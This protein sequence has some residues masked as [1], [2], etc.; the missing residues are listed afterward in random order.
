MRQ[1]VEIG[2]KEKTPNNDLLFGGDTVLDN[3]TTVEQWSLAYQMQRPDNRVQTDLNVSIF[4][5][6]LAKTRM[7]PIMRNARAPTLAI[8]MPECS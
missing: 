2:Y 6:L 3:D 4:K 5:A 8:A 7:P 1:N